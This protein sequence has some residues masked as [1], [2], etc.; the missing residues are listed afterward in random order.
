MRDGEAFPPAPLILRLPSAHDGGTLGD[1]CLAVGG[2]P[3]AMRNAEFS[4]I[5][6]DASK[7]IVGD[8]VWEEDE[9]HSPSLE[10][11]C[12]LVSSL[13]YPLFVRGAHNAL[14]CTLS[15][16]LLHRSYGRIYGLDLGK[17]HHNPACDYIGEI[18]KHSWDEALRD[19]NAYV[20]LDITAPASDPVAVWKQFCTEANI[21][22]RGTMHRPPP[23][24]M[25]ML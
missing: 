2:K 19:K 16:V 14:A 22:H 7:E 23:I 1:D 8:I 6:D 4:E 5:M 21:T 17:D 18:H 24:Q 20:P 9:D 11:R 13:G 15:Y 3:T 12:T 25:D 10:F